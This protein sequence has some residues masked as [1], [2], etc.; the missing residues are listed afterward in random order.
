MLLETYFKP[1]P[2]KINQNFPVSTHRGQHGQLTRQ[3]EP[4][5]PIT[6]EGNQHTFK[7]QL[8]PNTYLAVG[9]SKQ[10]TDVWHYLTQR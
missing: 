2:F 7:K 5:A 8:T 4:R 3:P 10:V 9:I 1:Y 6:D